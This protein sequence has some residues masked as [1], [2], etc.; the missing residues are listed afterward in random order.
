MWQEVESRGAGQ[1]GNSGQEAES[2]A[3]SIRHEQKAEQQIK[4]RKGIGTALGDAA[5]ICG[6]PA[7]NAVPH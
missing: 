1:T 4:R 5:L 3:G 7:K 6:T 2:R